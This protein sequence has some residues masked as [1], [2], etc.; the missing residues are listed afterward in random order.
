MPLTVHLKEHP[1]WHRRKLW[2]A[3][4]ADIHRQA[5]A[6]GWK[7]LGD[8][9]QRCRGHKIATGLQFFAFAR[10]QFGLLNGT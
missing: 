3:L 9:L 6:Q 4:C 5:L 10:R 1:R 8:Q 7:H 2:E